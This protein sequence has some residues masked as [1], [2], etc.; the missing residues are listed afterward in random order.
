MKKYILFII[1]I[2]LLALII[3]PK[4]ASAGVLPFDFGEDSLVPCGK[5]SDVSTA[6]EKCTLCHVFK[7]IKNLINLFL[8]L[9]ILIAP[10]VIIFGAFM[11]LTSGGS[12]ERVAYGKRVI[13]YVVIG[14][15]ITF[16]A[17]L[18]VN[19]LM[20]ELANPDA[21]PWPWNKIECKAGIPDN[22]NGGDDEEEEGEWCQRSDPA[23]SENWILTSFIENP[24]QKGDASS[25]LTS[26]LNCMYGRLSNLQ[27][28]SISSNVICAN[29]LCDTS[30][31]SCGHAANSCHFGGTNCTG[32]SY[33]VDFHIN[34]ACSTIRDAAKICDSTAWINWEGN[35]TH[36]SVNNRACGCNEREIGNP[37]P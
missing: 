4:P 27:I 5:S 1:F 8:S 36:V 17:W 22:G 15:L 24:K 37:C 29:P 21:T 7:G 33:A 3:I 11:I 6:D 20:N 9:I 31:S 18:L 16:G 19:T 35:H 13:V 34:L 30:T 28:N 2:V 23:G 25:R 32:L 12:P 14:L 26:F 10:V